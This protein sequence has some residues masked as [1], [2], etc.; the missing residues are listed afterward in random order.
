MTRPL[1]HVLYILHCCNALL[2]LPAFDQNCAKACMFD[3][4]QYSDGLFPLVI[5]SKPA[6]I[7]NPQTAWVH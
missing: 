3:L 6:Y 7:H 4:F 1:I 2:F 5:D